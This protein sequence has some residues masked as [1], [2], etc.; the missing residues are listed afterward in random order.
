MVKRTSAIDPEQKSDPSKIRATRTDDETWRTENIGRLLNNAIQRFE[1]RILEIMEDSGHG[2][3]NLS[4]FAVT[5]NLD[6]EGTRATDLARR[7]AVTKQSMGEL[8]LQLEARG[9]I[10]RQADPLD[11]RAKIVCF[12]TE[13]LAWLKTFKIAL[14]QAE[15]EM[16]DRIGSSALSLMKEGLKKYDSASTPVDTGTA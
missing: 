5:R 4:H 1:A 7:A 9:V 3:F 2:G 13:G 15:S 12:T 11:K 6:I 16:R 10:E 8:I 14:L